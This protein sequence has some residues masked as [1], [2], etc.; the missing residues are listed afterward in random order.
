MK[1]VGDVVLMLQYLKTYLCYCIMSG[2][3]YLGRMPT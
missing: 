2:A 1:K 3:S